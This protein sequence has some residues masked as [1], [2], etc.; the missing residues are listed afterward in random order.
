MSAAYWTS[1]LS[2]HDFDYRFSQLVSELD[3]WGAVRYSSDGPQ[4]GVREFRVEVHVPTVHH[5]GARLIYVESYAAGSEGWLLTEYQYNF[6][7]DGRWWF[8]AYHHHPIPKVNPS[9]TSITHVHCRPLDDP[10]GDHY[11]GIWVDAMEAHYE[12]V[13]WAAD[14]SMSPDCASLRPLLGSS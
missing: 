14:P 5:P 13:V 7:D 11:R 4:G 9:G 10:G 8:F 12:F 6:V 1:P 2:D 3:N